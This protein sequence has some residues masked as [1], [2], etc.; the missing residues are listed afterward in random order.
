VCVCVPA[1]RSLL[2]INA[3]TP[4]VDPLLDGS[5]SW[6]EPFPDACYLLLPT[7]LKNNTNPS[8]YLADSSDAGA[9]AAAAAAFGEHTSSAAVLAHA[10]NP[11]NRP[12]VFPE[13]TFKVPC[14][15]HRPC[16]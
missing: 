13:V 2:P 5:A 11:N 14:C 16:L 4:P 8:N 1:S 15:H 12:L 6:E 3:L 10:N 9:M 7:G